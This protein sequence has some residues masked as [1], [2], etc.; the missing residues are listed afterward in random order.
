MGVE[1]PLIAQFFELV[2]EFA[3]SFG[4]GMS[5]SGALGHF[6]LVGSGGQRGLPGRAL[7]RLLHLGQNSGHNFLG[8]G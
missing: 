5:V 1:K 7:R 6:G 8:W 2:A 4:I 3:S